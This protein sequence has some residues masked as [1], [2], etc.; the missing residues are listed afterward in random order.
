MLRVVSVL[1]A[2]LLLFSTASA[3]EKSWPER[4]FEWVA[5]LFEFDDR[6]TEDDSDYVLSPADSLTLAATR[7][8]LTSVPNSDTLALT[9][10]WPYISADTTA[11]LERRARLHA[12]TRLLNDAAGVL[13]L[14]T[15]RAV[16]IIYRSDQRP[17]R[18]VAMARRFTNVQELPFDRTLPAALAAAPQ[19]PTV[20]VVDDS[21][22]QSEANADWFTPLLNTPT[23]LTDVANPQ[24]P[25][26]PTMIVHFGSTAILR[27]IPTG[28]V[29]LNCP[30]RAKESEAFL[31]QMLFGA[32]SIVSGP[33]GGINLPATRPGYREPELLNFDRERFE[34][35]DY[36]I[37][38]AIRYRAMPGA[39][40]VVLKR[41]QV[42][43]EQ[44]YGYQTTERQQAVSPGDRYDLASI[45]KAAATSLAVMKLYDQGRLDLTQRVR[46]Y[47]PEFSK[48]AIGYYRIDQ[49]L[50]HHSGLDA[51]LPLQR[52]IGRQHVTDSLDATHRLPLGPERWLDES[53]PG[54]VRGDLVRVG[55]TRRPIYRY[56]DVNYVLLQLIVEQI[57]GESLHTFVGRNFYQPLGLGELGYRPLEAAPAKRLIPTSTDEW[58]RGGL[59]RGYAQDEGAALLGGVAGHAGL[60][61]NAHDL[62]Y[63]F[64]FL[65]D[66]GRTPSG[67]Q[68]LSPETVTLFTQRG[69]YNHRALGFDRLRAGWP[70]VINAGAGENTFGHL[71]F[72]GTSVWADPDND[73]VFVL[74]TNRVHPD[75]KNDKFQ[76]L[77]V[78]GRAHTAVYRA[79]RDED[80]A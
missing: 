68:L 79:L 61:G 58:M 28:T 69:P 14:L 46:D 37:N 10:N 59:L 72:T 65:L 24:L 48:R 23:V 43:Y 51:D 13:P 44:A 42:V 2:S 45:T 62:A 30:L 9:G 78:R 49:L 67:Q 1:V 55:R 38:R 53:I 63:L 19:L 20:L 40:V 31:A 27:K 71:G 26:V 54:K 33:D 11:D 15:D 35:L 64:Q 57:S 17:A 70:Q 50:T 39:Q 8:L 52:Y 16:R 34:Q 41:G 74:L 32:E 77:G 12:Q 4:L 75:P 56:S 73:L 80:S 66:G 36:V 25:S 21:P 18:F 3:E 6:R 29:L 60:F 47:L 76:Q 7:A 5:E 22:G